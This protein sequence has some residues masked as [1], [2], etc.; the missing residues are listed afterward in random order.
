MLGCPTCNHRSSRKQNECRIT[1]EMWARQRPPPPLR[2]C[3]GFMGFGGWKWNERTKRAAFHVEGGPGT[4]TT[5]V[6]SRT[7]ISLQPAPFLCLIL[8]PPAALIAV[9]CTIYTCSS[10]VYYKV[11]SWRRERNAE[12]GMLLPL[13]PA[14]NSMIRRRGRK[15]TPLSP[16]RLVDECR[17]K[18]RVIINE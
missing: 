18:K 8:L 16:L 5:T 13:S 6:G 9:V 7:T 14:F 12:S 10:T 1:A 11:V 3:T 15:I 4:I 17:G 2:C